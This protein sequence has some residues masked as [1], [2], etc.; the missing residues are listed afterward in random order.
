MATRKKTPELTNALLELEE[1]QPLDLQPP[2]P[3]GTRPAPSDPRRPPS[4]RGQRVITA[5]VDPAVHQQLRTLAFELD[6]PLQTL[7]L[8]ALGDLFQKHGRPRLT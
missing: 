1:T 5:Y 4:R 7:L 3:A 6:T 2:A 8:D